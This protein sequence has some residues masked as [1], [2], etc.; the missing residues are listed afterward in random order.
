MGREPGGGKDG[1]RSSM[2]LGDKS[3]CLLFVLDEVY[4]PPGAGEDITRG[5]G[6]GENCDVANSRHDE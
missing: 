3:V 2:N 1:E 4:G 5:G 6:G